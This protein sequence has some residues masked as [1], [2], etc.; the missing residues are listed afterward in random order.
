MENEDLGGVLRWESL[1]M[2][3]SDK[4]KQPKDTIVSLGRSHYN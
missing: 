3:K 1:Y 2:V 4:N